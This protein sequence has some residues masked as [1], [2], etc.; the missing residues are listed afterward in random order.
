[1]GV[2]EAAHFVSAVQVKQ[3]QRF[4]QP[5]KTMNEPIGRHTRLTRPQEAVG[6]A[7]VELEREVAAVA[8]QNRLAAFH[9]GDLEVEIL[10]DLNQG[11]LEAG[12]LESVL[13]PADKP[14]RVDLGPDVLE[15]APDK[16]RLGL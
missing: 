3:V 4:G 2:S 6:L 16:S 9:E 14:D 15:Q 11:Q 7:G 5:S 1:M 13:N 8:V 12:D 10:E